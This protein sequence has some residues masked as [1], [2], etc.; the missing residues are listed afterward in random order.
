MYIMTQDRKGLINLDN[1]LE[2]YY[3]E[4]VDDSIA[5]YIEDKWGNEIRIACY[6]NTKEHE[7][8]IEK[9]AHCIGATDVYYMPEE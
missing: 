8:Q 1:V 2:I 6:E 7:N 5:Y 9:I 3:E 4:L